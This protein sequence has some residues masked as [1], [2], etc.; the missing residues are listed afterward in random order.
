MPYATFDRDAFTAR[1]GLG[2]DMH[3]LNIGPDYIT[4]VRIARN[5]ETTVVTAISHPGYARGVAATSSS[6]LSPVVSEYARLPFK[7]ASFDIIFSYHALNNISQQEVT[8]MLAEAVR[9]LKDN[10]RMALLVWSLNP[11]NKAQSSHMQLLEIL[12]RLGI[13]HLHSFD[14]IS[15]WLEAAG[16][17]EITMELVTDQIQV[18]DNWVHSH[19]KRLEQ[20]TDEHAKDPGI[21]DIR[22]ELKSYR[23]HV[24]EFG[25]ELL[26]SIQFTA[27]RRAGLSSIDMVI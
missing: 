1:T 27:H 4:P 15:R 16:F 26:P 18:P 17:E 13:I 22:E 24:K 21:E 14:T 6:T 5:V 19:I 8:G 2:P 7:R 9:L 25:E 3:V 11:T 23:T 12:N 10:C 20:L